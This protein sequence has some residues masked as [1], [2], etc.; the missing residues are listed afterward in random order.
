[1]T[2]NDIMLRDM[3]DEERRERM[4]LDLYRE[5]RERHMRSRRAWRKLIR[6]WLEI[7]GGILTLALFALVAWLFL[8]ATPDQFSAECEA[9]RAEMEAKGE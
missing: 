6:G 5:M 2:I 8:A 3:Q 1:M 7:I 4:L 9:L